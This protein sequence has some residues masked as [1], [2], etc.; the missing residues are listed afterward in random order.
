MDYVLVWDVVPLSPPGLLPAP[1]I[2]STRTNGPRCPSKT[3]RSSR[4]SLSPSREGGID[5]HDDKAA[6]VVEQA[7]QPVEEK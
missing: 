5:P 4:P 7:S 6:H 3:R 2:P 1:P